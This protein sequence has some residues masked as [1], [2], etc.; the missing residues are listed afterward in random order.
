MIKERKLLLLFRLLEKG[1][2]SMFMM[3]LEVILG[4]QVLQLVQEDIMK[5]KS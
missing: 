1:F 3:N 5:G 4:V 2:G